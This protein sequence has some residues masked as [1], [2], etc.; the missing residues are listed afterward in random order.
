[1]IATPVDNATMASLYDKCVSWLERL[2]AGPGGKKRIAEMARANYTTFCKVFKGKQTNAEDFIGWLERLGARMV[3][4]DEDGVSIRDVKVITLL[5]NSESLPKDHSLSEKFRAVP[6]VTS[7]VAATPGLIP[8]DRI[9]SWIAVDTTDTLVRSR[10]GLLAVRVASGQR[11]MLP[12]IQ[13]GDLVFV[14]RHDTDP[15]RESDL[16]LIRDPEGGEAI[17]RVQVYTRRGRE[18]IT[19]YSHN[20]QEYPPDTYFLQEDFLGDFSKPIIGRVVGLW[21]DLTKR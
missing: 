18:M 4:P 15:R 14:D 9:L 10:A 17:K 11:S 21:A 5:N 3:F 2:S 20:A 1:M 8:D 16:F 7:E 6:I 19:F 12:L 13:G